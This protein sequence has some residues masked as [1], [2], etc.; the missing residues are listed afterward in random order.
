MLVYFLLKLE[1]TRIFL[2]QDML[3]HEV[4]SLYNL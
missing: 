3:L 4:G 2:G 1:T